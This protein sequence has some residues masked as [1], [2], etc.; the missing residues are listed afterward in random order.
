MLLLLNISS[1]ALLA[2]LPLFGDSHGKFETDSANPKSRYRHSVQQ[3]S[4]IG[5]MQR[6]GICPLDRPP[7]P[8][9]P[10]SGPAI[11]DQPHAVHDGA[12]AAAAS[13]AVP[14]A[15]NGAARASNSAATVS[16]GAA[17][18]YVELGSGRG[19]LSVALGKTADKSANI[20][21]V[22]RASCKHKG[23]K[24]LRGDPAFVGQVRTSGTR[25][26]P[27]TSSQ[28]QRPP[29]A[30]AACSTTRTVFLKFFFS[31]SLP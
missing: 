16:N 7:N 2:G 3:A 15:S 19:A 6:V 14:A 5:H 23:D 9:G 22:E 29:R 18:V 20:V 8:G 13:D 21:M 30:L 25:L 4:I 31:G 28:T 1:R 17:R 24:Y 27:P 10:T 11:Q 26:Y 12:A